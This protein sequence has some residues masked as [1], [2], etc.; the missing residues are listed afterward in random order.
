M[1][2]QAI[3]GVEVPAGEVFSFWRQIGRTTKARGF[4]NG[5]ELREGCLIKSV[6]GGLCQL[7][8]GL[9]EAALD[10]GLEIVERHAHSRV[11]P[12]SRAAR[13]RDAT[14]FLSLIHI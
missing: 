2:V 5:R 13:E 4:V 12:G 6:G 11:V 10:A 1:A 9:Y 8:N 7:S 14:V 3:D